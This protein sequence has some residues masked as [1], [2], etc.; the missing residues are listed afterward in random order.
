M[1]TDGQQTILDHIDGIKVEGD[2]FAE[3]ANEYWMLCCLRHGMDVISDLAKKCDDAVLATVS[4][5]TKVFLFGS[6]PPGVN[7]PLLTC[8]FHWYAM[9]AYQ[10]GMIVGNIAHRQDQSQPFPDKYVERVM[11]GILAFRHKVA[12]HFAWT[13]GNKRDNPAERQASV[14]QMPTFVDDSYHVGVMTLAVGKAGDHSTSA[15]IKPWS[16]TKMHEQLRAR[17]WPTV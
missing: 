7:M 5:G 14:M 15:A 11:P 17:Y 13:K 6:P 1:N 8:G 10:Y 3:P 2:V 12:A 4:E 16:I 9:S